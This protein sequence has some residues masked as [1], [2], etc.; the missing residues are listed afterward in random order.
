MVQSYERIKREKKKQHKRF[1]VKMEIRKQP[2]HA[3]DVFINIMYECCP[4]VERGKRR[5]RKQR[6]NSQNSNA[7]VLY[8][9]TGTFKIDPTETM[10]RL[11]EKKKNNTTI[12]IIR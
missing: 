4:F 1:D 8:L 2:C 9:F 11:F 5:E 3:C 6:Q 12:K 7:L 10:K